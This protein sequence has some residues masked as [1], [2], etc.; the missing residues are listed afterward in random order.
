MGTTSSSASFA[1]RARA[2]VPNG[3]EVEAAVRGLARVDHLE[4]WE[5]FGGIE[6]EVGAPA[7]GLA[8]PVVLRLVVADEPG[9][10]HEGL[11]L[12]LASEPLDRGDLAE[13]VLDLLAGVAVEVGLHTG[14]DVLGLPDVQDAPVARLEEV[15]AGRMGEVVGEADLA[16][17]RSPARAACLAQVAEREDAEPTAEIEE[18][19][20]DLRARLGIVQ[21]TVDRG[22]ARA[23]VLRERAQL[24][25]G[26]VRPDH[27]ARELGRAHGRSREQRVVEPAQVLVQEGEVEPRVVRH[28]DRAARELAEGGEHL[29]DGGLASH[30][31]VADARELGDEGGIDAPGSTNAWNTPRRSPPR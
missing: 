18:P 16:E 27:A 28:E 15:D 23:E 13:E 4:S 6:L 21:R 14:A 10:E 26:H 5:R 2:L 3:S 22:R 30:Q 24:H 9:L 20:Q 1:R 29:L 12:A 17:V 8:A 11:E 7:P 25:V 31:L 19:V